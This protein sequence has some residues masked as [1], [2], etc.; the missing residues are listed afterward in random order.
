MV[1]PIA[2]CSVP[3]SSSV[4]VGSRKA[5]PGAEDPAARGRLLRREEQALR[6]VAEP[7]A[8][9]AGDHVVLVDDR[10]D[11]ARDDVPVLVEAD[12]HDRLDVERVALA[13]AAGAIAFVVVELQRHADERGDR[14]RQLFRELVRVRAAGRR[15][16]G[17][18]WQGC[19]RC[20]ADQRRQSLQG[21]Y[22]MGELKARS[23]CTS[24]TF[25]GIGSLN[26]TW[27]WSVQRGVGISRTRT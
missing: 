5:G 27:S 9:V 26:R 19:Q 6:G 8:A 11:R 16:L 13:V 24:G 14:V 22:Q 4:A 2:H 21:V 12:R 10:Q 25:F 1:G 18:S 20:N 23:W 17:R 15:F 3:S 7:R